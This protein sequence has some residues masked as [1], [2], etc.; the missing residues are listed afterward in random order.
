M[1]AINAIVNAIVVSVR[2]AAGMVGVDFAA[3]MLLLRG[4][5]HQRHQRT[6]TDAYPWRESSCSKSKSPC[7]FDR[8]KRLDR[9][10]PGSRERLTGWAGC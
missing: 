10:A 9:F 4:R 5:I 7:D 1:S 6:R 8:T 2:K 3:A